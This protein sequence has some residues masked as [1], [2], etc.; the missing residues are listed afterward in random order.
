MNELLARTYQERPEGF[1]D[2]GSP[3]QL[4]SRPSQMPANR[5]DKMW[6][7][8]E[9]PEFKNPKLWKG[10]RILGAGYEYEVP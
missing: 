7:Q 8:G 10:V 5:G 6:L 4:G 1:Q 3:Q 9:I 2:Y